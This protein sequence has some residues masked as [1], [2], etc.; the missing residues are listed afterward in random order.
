MSVKP[1]SLERVSV[2]IPTEVADFMEEVWYRIDYHDD[3]V[4]QVNDDLIQAPSLVADWG[5]SFWVIACLMQTALFFG[6]ARGVVVII[7]W[8]KSPRSRA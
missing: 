1:P 8:I 3:T 2:P 6:A 5:V 7:R 4:E